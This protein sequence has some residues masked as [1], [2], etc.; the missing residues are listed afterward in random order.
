[1]YWKVT[2]G[3]SYRRYNMYVLVVNRS[4]NYVIRLITSVKHCMYNNV[5]CYFI[6]YI[7]INRYTHNHH[8]QYL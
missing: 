8:R 7:T 4:L 2:V 5:A 1:M 3:Y 6:V